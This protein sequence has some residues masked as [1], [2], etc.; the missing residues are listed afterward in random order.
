MAA[1]STKMKNGRAESAT[2]YCHTTRRGD[3]SPTLWY[4][5]SYTM[6]HKCTIREKKKKQPKKIEET[7]TEHELDN[8]QQAKGRQRMCRLN[9][10]E[11]GI[12]WP[13]I[14]SRRSPGDPTA[15]QNCGDVSPTLFVVYLYMKRRSSWLETTRYQLPLT[16]D[17]LLTWCEDC[18]KNL[19]TLLPRHIAIAGTLVGLLLSIR[20]HP[21]L[22][23]RWQMNE[24]V[25]KLYCQQIDKEYRV[26]I[27]MEDVTKR[28]DE[29]P[30]QAACS[31]GWAIIIAQKVDRDYMTSTES[32][33]L[34]RKSERHKWPT[35]ALQIWMNTFCTISVCHLR[36]WQE[37]HRFVCSWFCPHPTQCSNRSK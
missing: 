20:Y 5:T 13:L 29:W 37:S 1:D 36:N 3:V 17:I 25:V 4:M 16:I 26:H 15:L 21:L 19:T 35:Y 31:T 33:S 22:G 11:Q 10:K 27:Y 18:T 32:I 8:H 12:L 14:L 2:E 23:S 30:K 34:L 9:C 28:E 7:Y 24:A 6:Y